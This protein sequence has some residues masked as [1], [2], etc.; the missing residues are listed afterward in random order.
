[1]EQLQHTECEP[2]LHA[3]QLLSLIGSDGLETFQ[4]IDERAGRKG[5]G[6]IHH[7]TLCQLAQGLA[8]MNAAG[9]GIFFMVNGGDGRGR[10]TANVR[11]VR[12]LFVDLDGAPLEPVLRGPL[13][14][15]ATVESSPGRFHAYWAVEGVGLEDFRGFQEGLAKRFDGD[16]TVKDLPRV[17]RLPGY[18]HLKNDPFLCRV[19]DIERRP[20]Y[21]RAE[22][23]EAF[24]LT[25]ITD[26]PQKPAL[27]VV[28]D[29][30]IPEGQRNSR[31]FELARGFVNKGIAPDGVLDRIQ[32]VN[33]DRCMPPLCASEVD[34]IVRNACG[35]VA[36][37]GFKVPYALYDCEAYRKLSHAARTIVVAAYRRYDGTNNGNISLPFRDFAAEFCRAAT[38]YKERRAAVAAGFLRQV[39]EGKFSSTGVKTP[40]LYEVVHEL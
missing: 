12:A 22:V 4:T 21:T 39:G 11:Q 25:A 14:P 35:H 17:M 7:G 30:M 15:H 29:D 36:K 1:M 40:D 26:A 6:G 23:V 28:R 31:L 37:G 5:A 33:A 9:S 16:R 32:K 24:G 20:R 18:L 3:S 10:K 34:T 8:K 19:L 38:F 2:P 13:M 27:R